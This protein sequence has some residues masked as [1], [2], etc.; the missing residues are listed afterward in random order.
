MVMNNSD[1]PDPQ[2]AR[3]RRAL[4]LQ[5][6]RRAFDVLLE[7]APALTGYRF[8]PGADKSLNEMHYIDEASGS[9]PFSL[10]A[11]DGEL[12]F[13]VHEAGFGRVPGGLPALEA[14]LGPVS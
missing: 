9:L 4:R 11:K 14:G 3:F 7:Y 5:S 13:D 6:A 8:E 1:Q 2:L 12:L 10:V